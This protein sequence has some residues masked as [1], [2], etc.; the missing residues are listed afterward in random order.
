MSESGWRPSTFD[1]RDIPFRA[2]PHAA[3]IPPRSELAHPFRPR[4]QGEIPCCVSIA[5]VT[6]MEILDQRRP[7]SATLS[8]L[9]HY[10]VARAD[11][12]RPGMLDF[13]TALQT[14][15][16]TGI[17]KARYHAPAYDEA[18]A[19]TPPTDT[20]FKDAERQRLVGW[21]P[22]ARRIQYEVLEG[23]AVVEQCRIAIA[24]GFPILVG[25]W[26]T[27]AY[28]ALS[29]SN[30]VHGPPPR[31]PSSDGHAV[32]AVGYDDTKRALRVKD[33]RGAGFADAGSWWLPYPALDTPLIHELWI[34][35]KISYD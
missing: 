4:D 12:T 30:P 5:L 3:R 15:A 19:K 7:P 20:A 32:V 25:L 9:F 10:Y 17:S 33:S 29:S 28:K 35:R 13:R 34:L 26:M 24:S 8:P 18:G 6:A 27:S 14:A 16:N 22:E 21:D 1:G 11:P 23:H 2:P 31:E